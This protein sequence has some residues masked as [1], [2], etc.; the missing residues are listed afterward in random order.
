MNVWEPSCN[1][2]HM[3]APLG[4]YFGRVYASD[5]KDYGYALM[6]GVWDFLQADL[7]PWLSPEIDA[8]ICNPPYNGA[9]DFIQRALL[10]PGVECVAAITRLNF[11]ESVGRYKRLFR[12]QPPSVVAQFVERVPMFHGRL[13]PT[14]STATAYAWLVWSKG[15]DTATELRWIPPCRDKLE[16]PGDYL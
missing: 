3:A 4:D 10:V 11:L 12:D 14:G 2:G 7:P 15:W 5:I 9:E 13:D 16:R 1:V 8:V 6:D